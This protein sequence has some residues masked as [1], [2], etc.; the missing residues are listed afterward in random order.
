MGGERGQGGVERGEEEGGGKGK[1]VGE[2]YYS[3]KCLM[4]TFL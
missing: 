3:Y 4:E 2:R 1:R